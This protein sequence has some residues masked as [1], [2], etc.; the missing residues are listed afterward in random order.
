MNYNLS[1]SY[2]SVAQAKAFQQI[3]SGSKRTLLLR[4]GSGSGKTYI[5]MIGVL[6]R[7]MEF[8]N[9]E[10]YILKTDLKVLKAGFSKSVIQFL[11]DSK[12]PASRNK[13]SNS[14]YF[15]DESK[16]ELYLA[17]GSVIYL[18]PIRSP[19]PSN[20]KGDSALLGLNA[21]TILIDEATTTHFEWYQFFETRARSSHS[22]PP[23][24]ILTENPDARA[25]SSHYFDKQID[26]ITLMPLTEV[27][28][29]AMTVMRIEAWENLLQDKQYLE[30]LKNSGNALRFYY[31]E[32]DKSPD[33]G[34]IYQYLTEPM[35]MR[36]FN[37]YSLDPGYQ[38]RTAIVQIGFGGDL[39]VNIKELCYEQ[40][41]GHEDFMTQVQKIIDK[42]EQYLIEIRKRLLPGQDNYLSD[43]HYVPHLIVDCARTDLIMDIDKRFNYTTINGRLIKSPIPKIK[44]I[45]CRKGELKYY[46]IERVK[47]LQQIVDSDSKNYLREI[48]QYRYDTTKTDDEKVPDGEDD[49][50]D[51]ALYG[52]RYIVEDIFD[53]NRGAVVFDVARQQIYERIKNI[54]A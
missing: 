5:A 43:M 10:H 37:L 31:G 52:M 12:I 7:A 20:A 17:N 23:L 42:H 50:L 41:F 33:Y 13:K 36:F 14:T 19:R 16:S 28:K 29:Q 34:Q 25:W 6:I 22:C 1:I 54:P 46:S 51:A 11:N 49:L 4:G 15:Y 8:R 2:S 40:G 24:I 39:T 35:P 27:Q 48:G 26:P 53:K 44:V 47:K 18:R 3:S 45:P 9:T 30:I 21:E 32:I 38:A